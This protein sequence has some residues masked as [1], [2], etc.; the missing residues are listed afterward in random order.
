MAALLFTTACDKKQETENQED[1][2]TEEEDPWKNAPSNT[3]SRSLEQ[4]LLD[5]KDSMDALFI[6]MTQADSQ[7]IANVFFLVKSLKDVKDFSNFTLS[8]EIKKLAEE[9]DALRYNEHTMSQATH[10]DAYDAAQSKLIDKLKTLPEDT[11]NFE[12]AQTCA[13][14]LD[15]IMKSD[16]NDLYLRRDYMLLAESFNALLE[17]HQSEIQSSEDERVKKLQPAPVF[18][19]GD[20]DSGS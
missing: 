7:R 11:P 13:N 10:M 16:G 6:T 19:Y 15:E 9:A 12:N 2:T 18:E 1:N 20:M 3:D 4:K 17:Q 14:T 5:K 8:A